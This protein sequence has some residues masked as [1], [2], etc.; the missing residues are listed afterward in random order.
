M[1]FVT[2]FVFNVEELHQGAAVEIKFHAIGTR[3]YEK[4]FNGIIIDSNP[5]EIRVAYVDPKEKA[6]RI[7]FIRRSVT[8]DDVKDK[9]ITLRIL[10]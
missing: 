1:T 6:K 10:V 8:L 7:N 4:I 3:K 9:K 5:L 2:S